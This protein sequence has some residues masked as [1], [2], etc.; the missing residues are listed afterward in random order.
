MA[1]KPAAK[2]HP[3]RTPLPKSQRRLRPF[4]LH[5]TLEEE[6]AVKTAAALDED[7]PYNWGRRMMVLAARRRIRAEGIKLPDRADGK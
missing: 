5:L 3:G 7:K 4:G 2:K 6:E 1:K